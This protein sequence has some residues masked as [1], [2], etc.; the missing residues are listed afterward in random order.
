MNTSCEFRGFTSLIFAGDVLLFF[1]LLTFLRTKVRVWNAEGL[2][3]SI[4]ES[5]TVEWVRFHGQYR[6]SGS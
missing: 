3:H 4:L 5:L 6:Y 1:F 2:A